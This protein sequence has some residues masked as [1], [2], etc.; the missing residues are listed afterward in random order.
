MKPDWD[1]GLFLVVHVRLELGQGGHQHFIH[2]AAVH[3]HDFEREIL[4]LEFLPAAGNMSQLI[5]HESAQGLVAD[6]LLF[7][8]FIQ[9]EEVFQFVDGQQT[10][11]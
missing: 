3:I 6:L 11:Q 2:A 8:E 7:G 5:H 10:I 4:K 1:Q 9:I